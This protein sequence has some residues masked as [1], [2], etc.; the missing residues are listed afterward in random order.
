MISSFKI[1]LAVVAT[2]LSFKTMASAQENRG[3]SEQRAACVSDAFRLCSSYI[4]DGT[5]IEYCLT[6]KKSELSQS[7]RLVSPSGDSGWI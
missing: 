1:V 5:G 2:A 6:Q 7:C 3:T 4:P